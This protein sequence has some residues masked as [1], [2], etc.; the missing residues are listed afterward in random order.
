MILPIYLYGASI[1]RKRC[2]VV[3]LKHSLYSTLNLSEL[4]DNMFETMQKA[5]GIGLAAPQVGFDLRLFV[6]DNTRLIGKNLAAFKKV[7]INP[8]I[9]E[10]YGQKWDYKEGCL[11]IPNINAHITRHPNIKIKYYDQKGQEYTDS[12]NGMEARIIQHEYDHI[13]G[14]LFIDYLPISK[15]NIIKTKLNKVIKGKMKVNYRVK[16]SEGKIL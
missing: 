14:K 10:E 2:Q 5:E 6:V 8:T 15:R 4:I 13:N 7:F 9:I 16:T 12:F 3:K 1:L 11:S